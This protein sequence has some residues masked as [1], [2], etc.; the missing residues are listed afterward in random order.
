L[1]LSASGQKL[2][3]G[4]EGNRRVREV[5]VATGEVSTYFFSLDLS[6]LRGIAL[7]SAGF[8]YV[9]DSFN[10]RICN[11]SGPHGNMTF[12]GNKGLRWPQG[13]FLQ[14]D[15]ISNYKLFVADYLDNRIAFVSHDGSVTP[16]AGNGT[17]AFANGVGTSAAFSS[18]TDVVLDSFSGLLYVVDKNNHCIRVV[19]Q[20][21]EVTTLAGSGTAGFADGVGNEASF[22]T[23][24][25]IALDASARYL[26][27]SD[28]FNHRIRLV[29]LLGNVT[30]L[31]GTGNASFTD[32]PADVA[33]FHSP[34]GV[35]VDRAG[36]VYVSDQ[37]N[38]RIR[39]VTLHP[40]RLV[41]E[42]RQ[43]FDP[44][45]LCLLL[46]LP[47]ALAVWYRRRRRAAT[48][49]LAKGRVEEEALVA[50]LLEASLHDQNPSRSIK[51]LAADV[52]LCEKLG[53]GGFATVHSARWCGTLV[54]AKV[55]RA[56][57]KTVL[58][59][60]R[61]SSLGSAR[62]A[63]RVDSI[64]SL[65]DDSSAEAILHEVTILAALRHPNIVVVYGFVQCPPMLLMELH[66]SGTLADLLLHSDLSSLGWHT[67]TEIMLGVACGVD[68]LHHQSPP[69]IHT[70]L[71]P[72]NV[73]MS[74]GIPR[75]S[76][77]GLSF[78]GGAPGVFQLRGTLAYIA[79]EVAL[80]LPVTNYEAL[81]SYGIGAIAHD[82]AHANTWGGHSAV[83]E[84]SFDY[85]VRESWLYRG[86]SKLPEVMDEE[87]F[88]A[89]RQVAE[90]VPPSFASVIRSCLAFSPEG[91]PSIREARM[92][93]EAALA[94]LRR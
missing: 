71:K 66:S 31:A 36:N 18:P 53:E 49:M 14:Y 27:V 59:R 88:H 69:I 73:L 21:G 89:A 62:P 70:D 13:I 38:N 45:W 17:A 52:T 24:V 4:D 37:D 41:P 94:D 76:D 46:L 44:R 29:S 20:T 55:Y 86:L 11:I 48:E 43:D 81:D 87:W 5:D 32:G 9:S 60:S 1:R 25:G 15:N 91:R 35:A 50:S 2:Y 72:Q 57:A 93:L 8:L 19:S 16:V 26:I 84:A 64:V 85:S 65:C 10:N 74:D 63:S 33:S 51:I 42:M 34:S 92:Q 82:V 78:S 90:H 6:N 54:A 40:T 30:T 22:N 47:L 56:S 79:P 80:Q 61:D 77:F 3:V 83:S 67:R 58:L 23:P 28:V 68:F 39:V 12:I 75:I 7:D